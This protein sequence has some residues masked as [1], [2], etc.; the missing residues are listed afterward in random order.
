MAPLLIQA[1]WLMSTR[2]NT[3]GNSRATGAANDDRGR[4]AMLDLA[5]PSDT[6]EYEPFWLTVKS[7][8]LHLK[9]ARVDSIGPQR[10]LMSQAFRRGDG[11]AVFRIPVV[12]RGGG[13]GLAWPDDRAGTAE[14]PGLRRGRV[15]DGVA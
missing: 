11:V 1:R 12:G 4:R 10:P 13:A 3:W 15:R 7:M 5:I 2:K 14:L 6:S 9:K 8:C